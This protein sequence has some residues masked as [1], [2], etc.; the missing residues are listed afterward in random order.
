MIDGGAGSKADGAGTVQGAVRRWLRVEGFVVLCLAVVL[1]ARG[2]ESWILFAAL[3]LAPDISLLGYLAGPR[4]GAAAYNALHS[5][6]GPAV[7]A[8]ALIPTGQ[9]AVVPLIWVAHIGF[10][11]TLG[12]GLK[13]PTEFADTH[14]GRIG[15][16]PDRT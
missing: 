5:Y 2:G 16:R 14:L 9:S 11:R 10:D 3:F 8:L 1:Y 15:H 7:L 12:F 13:Y 4:A 6:A